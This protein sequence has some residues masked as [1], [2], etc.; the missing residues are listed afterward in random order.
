MENE[1]KNMRLVQIR[2]EKHCEFVEYLPKEKLDET[3]QIYISDEDRLAIGET[4]CFDL[5]TMSVVDY[6]DTID[7]I[8]KKK[9]NLRL[10][11]QM[12]CFT[13][14]NRGKLWYDTL[15]DAQ[16]KE[17]K[18]WYKE[19]LNVTDTMEEP[20]F[21][22]FLS[23]ELEKF[24]VVPEEPVIEPMPETEVEETT[25][26]LDAEIEKENELFEIEEDI[27]NIR[28]ALDEEMILEE[29]V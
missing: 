17:L 28:D 29:E 22:K 1:I 18:I 13:I 15:T 9:N 10:R 8:I 2:D 6:D 11:R 7:N 21:P 16:K 24:Y 20:D 25:E 3:K 12:I 5:E 19:W 26:N 4:K 27:E 14:I 23:N